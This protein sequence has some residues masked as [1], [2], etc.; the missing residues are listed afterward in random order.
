MSHENHYYYM[1]PGAMPP[2]RHRTKDWQGRSAPPRDCSYAHKEDD[3]CGS[4]LA[5]IASYPQ[6]IIRTKVS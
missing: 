3:Y 5:Q 1:R 4:L 2:L 6:E